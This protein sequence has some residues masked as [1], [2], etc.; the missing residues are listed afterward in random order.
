MTSAIGSILRSAANLI[1]PEENQEPANNLI[2]TREIPRLLTDEQ[3]KEMAKMIDNCTSIKEYLKEH[4]IDGMEQLRKYTK[5]T[6]VWSSVGA[7]T[8]YSV[9]ILLGLSSPATTTAIGIGI[10]AGA[11]LGIKL[12]INEER[13]LVSISPT[14]QNWKARAIQER[15][16]DQYQDFI[17]QDERLAEFLCPITLDLINYPMKAPDT[18]PNGRPDGTVFE[19]EQIIA[20]INHYMR[21]DLFDER[22]HPLRIQPLHPAM[23]KFDPTYHKKVYDR[24]NEI[25]NESILDV[26]RSGLEAFRD[27]IQ[28]PCL[29]TL[30]ELENKLF[31]ELQ[32]EE[33]TY[34]EYTT[35]K[36]RLNNIFNRG[37][38]G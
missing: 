16:Y 2:Q 1:D 10:V 9:S 31:Q 29:I 13:Y 38:N 3:R 5:G 24:L 30:N 22:T 12:T 15:V 11:A 28:A 37:N 23:I 17:K 4:P 8:G 33:I 7:G 26:V 19:G 25:L 36:N 32:N 21:G 35:A 14:Y 34:D 20:H 27:S 18:T 6:L